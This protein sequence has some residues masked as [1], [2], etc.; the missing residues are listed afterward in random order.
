MHH[1]YCLNSSRQYSS[2][3]HKKTDALD[4]QLFLDTII[5]GIGVAGVILGLYFQTLI[6][7]LTWFISK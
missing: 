4:H 5:G 6:E 3:Y 1:M 7:L 2:K